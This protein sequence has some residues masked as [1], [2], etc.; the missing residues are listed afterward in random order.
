MRGREN[1]P[2]LSYLFLRGKCSHCK[3]P[4][5]RKGKRLVT[6]GKKAAAAGI[7]A[8]GNKLPVRPTGRP[9]RM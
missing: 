6:I 2:L 5:S 9:Q 3:T 7:A 1:I 8:I 4:I